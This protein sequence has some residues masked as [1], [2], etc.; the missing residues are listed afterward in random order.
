MSALKTQ[1][2]EAI[3]LNL[4]VARAKKGITATE[5]AFKSKVAPATISFIENAKKE[6][7]ISTLQRLAEALGIPLEDLLK[8]E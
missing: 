6:V 8:G 4:K 3:A 5:L 1:N 2:L 7:R